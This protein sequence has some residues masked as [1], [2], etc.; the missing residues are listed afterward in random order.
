MYTAVP[1]VINF[2]IFRVYVYEFVQIQLITNSF[3]MPHL[4]DHHYFTRGYELLILNY[5]YYCYYM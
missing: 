1:V 3:I 2:Y 4:I 5:T